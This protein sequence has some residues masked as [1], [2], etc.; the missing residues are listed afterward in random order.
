LLVIEMISIG[1][2]RK[3]IPGQR[4][5]GKDIHEGEERISLQVR[6]PLLSVLLKAKLLQ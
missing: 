2:N 5:L 4:T 3:R 6:A 1:D